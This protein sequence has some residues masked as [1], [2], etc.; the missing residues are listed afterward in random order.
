MD[1]YHER[2]AGRVAVRQ[3]WHG[4]DFTAMHGLGF[5]AICP[6]PVHARNMSIT[7]RWSERTW[8]QVLT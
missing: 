8:Q 4:T 3:I 7:Y 6:R 1:S 5:E 2:V